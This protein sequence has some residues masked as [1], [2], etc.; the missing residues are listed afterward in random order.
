MPLSKPINFP[1]W[2]EE[3]SDLLKPPVNNYCMYSSEDYT[4]M[5]V[6]GPNSR[7]DYHFNETEVSA[8]LSPLGSVDSGLRVVMR[9]WGLGL[10]GMVLSVQG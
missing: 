5:V 3:N 4:I 1:K 9:C 6:G 10:L 7:N 2:L 8:F